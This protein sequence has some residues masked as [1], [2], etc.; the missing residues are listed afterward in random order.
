VRVLPRHAHLAAKLAALPDRSPLK[1]ITPITVHVTAAIE[2]Q[3]SL[4]L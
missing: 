4:R 2:D 1:A 3:P